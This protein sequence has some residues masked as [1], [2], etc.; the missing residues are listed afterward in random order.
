ME[1]I[2]DRDYV[3]VK[4]VCNDSEIKYLIEYHDL[5]C[6]SDTLLSADVSENFRKMNL[7]NRPWLWWQAALKN[8]RVKF[9]LLADNWY[10]YAINGWKRNKRWN[11]S[12]C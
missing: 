3:H 6:K 4:R 7:S 5:Y 9:E 10:W 1:D 12:F 2:T 11:V 8:T